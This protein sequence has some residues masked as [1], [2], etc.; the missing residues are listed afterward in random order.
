MTETSYRRGGLVGIAAVLVLLFGVFT[1]T[2]VQQELIPDIQIPIFTVIVQSPDS[3]PEEIVSSSIAS[4]EDAATGLDGFRSTQSTV[5]NGLGV[6][7]ISL[8]FGSSVDDAEQAMRD[9]ID[10]SNLPPGVTA[11]ILKFDVSLLPVVQLSIEGDLSQSELTQI[12]EQQVLPALGSI[13]GVGAVDVVGTALN[14][15]AITIDRQAMLDAG[16]TFDAI[17]EALQANNV[18]IPSGTI[19]AGDTTIPLETVAVFRSLD[20]IAATTLMAADGDTVQL[21]SIASIE[22]RES[23]A[24]GRNR[25][26]G[27]AAIG[28]SIAKTQNANTVTVAHA[29]LD[30]L[31]E[32]EPGLPEG[33]TITIFQDQAEFITESIA[34]V[35]E[36]GLIGG[37]LAIVVVFVFLANWR[38]TLITSVSIPLSIITAIIVLDQLGY[39]L[40][41]MT[42]SG[43]TIAIARVIDDSI[44]VLENIYRHMAEGERTFPAILNGAREVTIAILGATATTCAVF[45]PLGLIGGL[46]GQ[47]FLP[48]AVAV[49][50]A[51]AASLLI[52]ITVVPV[53][54]RY[55]LGGRVKAE[56]EKRSSDTL[57]GRIYSPLLTW[58]LGNRWKTLAIAGALFIGSLGLLP[59]LPVTFLPDSGEPI[60]TVEVNARP[61]QT[62]ESVLEQAIEIEGLLGQ[63]DVLRYQTV[64]TGASSDFGAIG[65]V[66]SGNSPN[67]AT[68]TVELASGDKNDVADE[69]RTAI[70]ATTGNG[71]VTVSASGGGFTDS[72]ISVT[73]AT[74]DPR[75]VHLLED[76]TEA[77]TQAVASVPNTA[78]VSNDLAS[79]QPSI[80]IVVDPVR[81][82]AE[83]LRP[84]DVAASLRNVSVQRT[85][86]S[87]DLG[88]GPM[89]VRMQIADAGVESIED[90]AALEIASGV[91][92]EDVATLQETTKQ[93]SIT[94]VDGQLASTISGDITSENVGAVS[95][96][97]QRAV[98]RVDLPDGIEVSIGGVA[99]DIEQGFA[100]MF[101]AI[102]ISVVVVYVIMATLFGSWLDP[103]VILFSLPLA[104]IGAIVALVVTGSALSI[105][106]LIGMLMLVGIV[107][108]NAI[109]MLE[110][111]ILLRKERG[112]DIHEAIVEGAQTRLRPVL[113]TAIAAM[114]ALVPLSLGLTEGALIAADLGRTVIGGLFTSTMLTLLVVPVVYSLVNDL[115]VRFARAPGQL[116]IE[117]A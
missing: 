49:V 84:E 27:Q 41:L 82:Q 117:E 104:V 76:A 5:V 42:L 107:V 115:K 52:A 95:T 83:G 43:L 65:Q 7:L 63:F 73:V 10:A 58:A 54:A 98:G 28:I 108:T 103:F 25:T 89:I 57:L 68:I 21:D 1:F 45:L 70:E 111:V 39:S 75:A 11:S 96:D 32:I 51:L 93:V 29:V 67:S 62:Q 48:F 24:A 17:A 59:F 101:I 46:I 23:P 38:T 47:L 19:N 86:T 102:A 14:E 116:D 13:D 100:D 16:L 8:E 112:Y 9:A 55:A 53:L 2:R 18:V 79:A 66:I 6:T 85:V 114:L 69:L 64:I 56:P 72:G 109:V 60:V 88:T 30:A 105:S 74:E 33:V 36:E 12:A 77:V 37:V 35:I 44:V 78:N 4:I 80:E 31:E 106:S 81:A 61:G 94:R 34:S 97:V 99:G 92:L 40:N 71:N 110:Y 91:R 87:A 90:L 20:D 26:N 50:A 22:V 113:M 3:P 15:V